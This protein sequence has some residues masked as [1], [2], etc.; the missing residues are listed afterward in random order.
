MMLS[1]CR[2]WSLII[3]ST[4]IHH[5]AHLSSPCACFEY[6]STNPREHTRICRQLLNPCLFGCVCV[7]M[8]LITSRLMKF[9]ISVISKS[10]YFAFFFHSN[11][12]YLIKSA[13]DLSVVLDF[14]RNTHLAT[15]I[16]M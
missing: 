2:Y 8:R 5:F 12:I 11:Y 3:K 6:D 9:R 15:L 4:T 14:F 7:C 1:F 16:Q 13:F 10:D